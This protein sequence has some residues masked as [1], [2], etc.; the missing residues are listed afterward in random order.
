MGNKASNGRFDKL[1]NKIDKIKDYDKRDY[2]RL[3]PK[4]VSYMIA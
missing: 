4:Q 2:F 3:L 1:K